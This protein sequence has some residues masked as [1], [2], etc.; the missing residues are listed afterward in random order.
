MKRVRA[1]AT[2]AG[3][4]QGVWFRETTRQRASELRLSGWVRN[5][6]NGDVEAVFEGASPDVEHALEFVGKGPPLARVTS[7]EVV[8]ETPLD[9]DD[10]FPFRILA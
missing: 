8:R 4:V 3:R 1:R 2:I 7:V 9:S 6:P 5:C 10:E